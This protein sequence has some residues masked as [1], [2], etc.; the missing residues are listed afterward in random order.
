M[1]EW[2]TT[3]DTDTEAYRKAFWRAFERFFGTSNAAVVKAM[4]LAK[5]PH[6]EHGDD[7]VERVAYGLRRTMGWIADAI[8]R[9][10]RAELHLPSEA[11]PSRG[12]AARPEEP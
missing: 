8:D 6:G 9:T 12:L 7:E 2:A 11:E 5:Y 10:V 4:L 1:P 3:Q